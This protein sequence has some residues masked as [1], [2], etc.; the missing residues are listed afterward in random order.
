MGLRFLIPALG[1]GESEDQVVRFLGEEQVA[2][3]RTERRNFA[4]PIPW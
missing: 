1:E 2:P 4:W 3:D